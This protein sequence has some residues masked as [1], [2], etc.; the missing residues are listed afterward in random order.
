MITKQNLIQQLKG[1][2][3]TPSLEAEWIL[4]ETSDEEK[5]QKIKALNFLKI[6]HF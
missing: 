2:S 1:I 4:Q 3:E 5:I 6:Q